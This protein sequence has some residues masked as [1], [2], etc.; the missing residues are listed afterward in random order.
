[1]ATFSNLSVDLIGTGYTLSA[2]STPP[3]T[4]STSSA[5]NISGGQLALSCAPQSESPAQ[6][7]QGIEL[8]AVTLDG[9]SQTTQAA[10][11]PLYV[12][13]DRGLEDV[14][15]SVSAYLMPTAGNPN[16]SCADVATFCNS[17]VGTSASNPQGQI[18]SSDFSVGGITCT[19][20]GGNVNPEP[21]PGP[22][23]S[24][25]TGSGAVSLCAAPA[26]HSAGTFKLGATYS[27]TI[28]EGTYA[29]QYQATVEYLAF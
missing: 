16:A 12:T 23:G 25:P 26:G 6:Q 4:G 3:Y 13:D 8:P 21:D 5:F 17:S 14:G 29:G 1:V 2:S 11:S 9:L 27:L 18:P 10:G 22:G 24:F 20:A 7:C 28:P 19:A 15:W